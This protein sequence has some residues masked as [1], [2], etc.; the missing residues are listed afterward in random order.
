[1]DPKRHCLGT[2]SENILYNRSG[3][4]VCFYVQYLEWSKTGLSHCV[5][6]RETIKPQSCLSGLSKYSFAMHEY[7][8]NIIFSIGAGGGGKCE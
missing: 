1:M 2:C 5:F 3:S 8:S 6:I 7:S 4:F